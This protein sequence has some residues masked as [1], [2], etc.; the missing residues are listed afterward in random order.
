MSWDVQND[1]KLSVLKTQ[2]IVLSTRYYINASSSVA[3]TYIIKERD[4]AIF[5]NSTYQ[6]SFMDLIISKLQNAWHISAID[7]FSI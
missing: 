7:L 6:F 4:S 5:K 3:S 1:S 2:A